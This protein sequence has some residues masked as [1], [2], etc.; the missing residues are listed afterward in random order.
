[1]HTLCPLGSQA[2]PDLRQGFSTVGEKTG[3][4]VR[5]APALGPCALFLAGL[6]C[7]VLLALFP[8]TQ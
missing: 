1:M 8:G 5:A 4:Q 2:N 6:P 3:P 7:L